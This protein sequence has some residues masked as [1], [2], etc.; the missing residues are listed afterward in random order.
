MLSV[1]TGAVHF[2]PWFVFSV[3]L[4]FGL[5]LTAQEPGHEEGGSA[6]PVSGHG[7]PHTHSAHAEVDTQQ[8]GTENPAHQHGED[9]HP[10]GEFHI[11]GR[12]ERIGQHEGYRPENN[13]QGCVD[14]T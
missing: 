7:D 11:V 9:S 6:D 10:H 2:P 4:I 1:Q 14:G 3:R 13:R 8:P 12:P 5:P